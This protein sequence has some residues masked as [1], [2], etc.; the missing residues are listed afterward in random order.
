MLRR[1]LE[2]PDVRSQVLREGLEVEQA[3]FDIAKSIGGSDR[4]GQDLR[5]SLGTVLRLVGAARGDVL[6][7][8]NA[9]GDGDSKALSWVARSD[10][11]DVQ[12]EFAFRVRLF[13]TEVPRVF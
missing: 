2:P 3:A 8:P 9:R 6:R 11:D 4:I 7:R 5:D 10:G 1:G 13:E 12:S